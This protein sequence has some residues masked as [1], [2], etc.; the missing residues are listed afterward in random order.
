MAS[1]TVASTWRIYHPNSR[2]TGCAVEMSVIPASGCVEGRLRFRMA[3]E[4]LLAGNERSFDW[5]EPIEFSLSII[6]TSY[7]IAVLTGRIDCIEYGK[8][9]L[10]RSP[11]HTSVVKF[12]HQIEPRPGYLLAVTQTPRGTDRLLSAFF[13]F[14][15]MEAIALTE[16]LRRALFP[17][18]FGTEVAHG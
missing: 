5:K 3:R 2:G 13:V 14:G 18:A 6:D 8:G 12:S 16:V 9:L 10:N 17:M 4:K 1:E 7:L 11:V 15:E